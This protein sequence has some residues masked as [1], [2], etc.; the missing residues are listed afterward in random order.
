MKRKIENKIFTILVLLLL[1][2]SITSNT[3]VKAENEST[4]IFWGDNCPHCATL[5]D[6]VKQKNLDVKLHI[7][8]KEIY[9]DGDNAELFEAI[10][11]KCGISPY[12][13]GV[14]LLYINSQCWVGG[15]EALWALERAAESV[16]DVFIENVS[17]PDN[18]ENI[19]IN[20]PNDRSDIHLLTNVNNIVVLGAI[21][22]G[23]IS[24][25]LIIQEFLLNKSNK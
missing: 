8:Y 1:L 22:L 9:L 3:F 23:I 17:Y 20:E 5:I 2:V 15:N 4:I 13:A 12:N 19:T 25:G 18:N 14:P 11:K 24:A 7:D 16:E 21:T 6:N 10:I